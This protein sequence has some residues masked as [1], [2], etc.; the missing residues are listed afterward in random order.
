MSRGMKEW[1]GE[2]L[3]LTGRLVERLARAGRKMPGYVGPGNFICHPPATGGNEKFLQW[4]IVSHLHVR[5]NGQKGG[6]LGF[7]RLFGKLP[8]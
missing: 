6:K 1:G 8:P 3:G 5:K 4:E 7:G 2:G